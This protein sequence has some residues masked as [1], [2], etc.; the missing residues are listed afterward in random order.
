MKK[1]LFILFAVTG[2][3]T[4]KAQTAPNNT[5]E[6]PYLVNPIVPP[7]HLLK[8]DSSTWLTK[9]DIKKN[10]QVLII[11]FSPDCDHCKH[12]MKDILADFSGFKD[13]EII[14]ATYQP[15]EEMK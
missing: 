10:R 12:Q 7:F 15:F 14:M 3:L 8:V 9:N 6:P 11:F 4:G 2:L 13:I 1:L 5:P